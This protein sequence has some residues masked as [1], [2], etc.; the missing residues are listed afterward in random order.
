M[1]LEAIGETEPSSEMVSR[2]FA[3]GSTSSATAAAP[4]GKARAISYSAAFSRRAQFEAGAAP[5][6]DRSA[7][8]AEASIRARERRETEAKIRE[9]RQVVAMHADNLAKREVE[10]VKQ[11]FEQDRA[12]R[13][14]PVINPYDPSIRWW[15]LAVLAV[16]CYQAVEM[17]LRLAFEGLVYSPTGLLVCNWVEMAID[18][19]FI[20]DSEGE[21]KEEGGGEQQ[22]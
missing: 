7:S 18:G 22:D 16:L 1:A 3:H 11:S 5:S 10:Q 13:R 20:A 4:R 17:P 2:S 8:R 15:E 6:R 21:N 14:C 19:I 9:Y 12:G